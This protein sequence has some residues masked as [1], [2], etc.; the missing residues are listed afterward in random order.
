MVS[1]NKDPLKQF[2]RKAEEAAKKANPEEKP[3][4]PK[5]P[6]EHLA[7][8]SEDQSKLIGGRGSLIG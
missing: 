8:W 3:A 2:F 1:R 7:D 6:G 4:R 5:T